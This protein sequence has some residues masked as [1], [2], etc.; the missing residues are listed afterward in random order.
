MIAIVGVVGPHSNLIRC[1]AEGTI[2]E[3]ESK[4][5]QTVLTILVFKSRNNKLILKSKASDTGTEGYQFSSVGN[6][7]LL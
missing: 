7:L 3:R 1:H 2:K 4:A 5:N 6:Q